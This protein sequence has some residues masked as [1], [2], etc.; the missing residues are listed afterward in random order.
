MR[1]LKVKFKPEKSNFTF[2]QILTI[3]AVLI[4]GTAYT[5][6]KSKWD[7]AW[8]KIDSMVTMAAEFEGGQL[9]KQNAIH[10]VVLNGT[11][12]EMGRQYGHLLKEQI[13][14]HFNELKNDFMLKTA[15]NNPVDRFGNR[16]RK[17]Y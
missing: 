10:I 4:F 14:W 1:N 12:Y 6:D 8:D 2:N 13:N 5:Q 17:H 3:I 16:T 11:Y 9:Y 15:G 7:P